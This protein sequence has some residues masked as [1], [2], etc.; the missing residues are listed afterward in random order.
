M[1]KRYI[2]RTLR[3]AK[4]NVENYNHYTPDEIENI[5]QLRMLKTD[6]LDDYP[7]FAVAHKA[8]SEVDPEFRAGY[9]ADKD[10]FDPNND[11]IAF[12]AFERDV[13]SVARWYEARKDF[14]VMI[15]KTNLGFFEDVKVKG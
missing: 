7:E 12:R 8:M 9:M 4:K 10:Y 2:N 13:K 6:V 15:V 14:E 3:W 1:E 11:R 5:M